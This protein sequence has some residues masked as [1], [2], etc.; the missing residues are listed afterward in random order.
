MEYL[1]QKACN[2]AQRVLAKVWANTTDDQKYDLLIAA[3]CDIPEE[4]QYLNGY[5]RCC[6][7]VVLEGDRCPTCGD[8]N[9]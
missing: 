4:L 5:M 2:Q 6:G 8:K 9:D 7:N 1:E 3:G